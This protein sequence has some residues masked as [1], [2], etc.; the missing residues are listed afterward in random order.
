MSNAAKDGGLQAGIEAGHAMAE[1]WHAAGTAALQAQQDAARAF[2]GFFT[3]GARPGAEPADAAPLSTPGAHAGRPLS[4]LMQSASALHEKLLA[5]FMAAVSSGNAGVEA[6]WR[7]MTEP[8]AWLTGAMGFGATGLEAMQGPAAYL[9]E[10]PMF[11]DLWTAERQQ[12]AVT[13]AWLDMSRCRL[14]HGAIVLAAW[15]RA[16]QI[17]LGEM[18]AK[19]RVDQH[20]PAGRA[21][22]TLWTE[23]ANRELLET[24][25]SEPFLRTQAAL[26]RAST[27]LK[28]AQREVVEA[29][30]NQFGLPT[31]TELDDVHRTVTTLRR[32]LRLLQRQLRMPTAGQADPARVHPAY[33]PEPR[34]PVAPVATRRGIN[35]HKPRSSSKQVRPGQ[36]SQRP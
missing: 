13:K 17:F 4:D 14:E 35:G 18:T 19:A 1:F 20:P 30:A 29:W 5:A 32:E 21:L 9:A 8:N 34:E 23:T 3:L 31:R 22:L 36:G 10:G 26:M 6:G 2:A 11:A 27:E 25:R 12:A 7:A 15:I 28:L 33:P 24:Q 16:G